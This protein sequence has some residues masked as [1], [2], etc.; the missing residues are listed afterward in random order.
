M[1]SILAVFGLAMAYRRLDDDKGRTYEL[2]H[3]VVKL[4]RGLLQSMMNQAHKVELFKNQQHVSHALHAK[5]STNTGMTVV[6]DHEVS[7]MKMSG[8]S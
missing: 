2:E 7:K 5:Y 3:A 8:G 6:G 4:M 1:Y